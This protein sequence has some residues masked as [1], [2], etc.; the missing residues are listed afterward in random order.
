MFDLLKLDY[1]F[2]MF[3]TFPHPHLYSTHL[4][5][6]H[7]YFTGLP[8]FKKWWEGKEKLHMWGQGL[9]IWENQV[10][11]GKSEYVQDWEL[12]NKPWFF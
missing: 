6:S 3:P 11:Y 9:K 10:Q 4:Y 8:S 2:H 7:L 1:N 5:T 12:W